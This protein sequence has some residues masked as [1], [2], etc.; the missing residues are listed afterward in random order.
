MIS[1]E[2][3]VDIVCPD[4][5]IKKVFDENIDNYTYESPSINSNGRISWYQIIVNAIRNSSGEIDYALELI[6]PITEL[7]RT[8]EALKK[9]EEEYRT[10]FESMIDP[11]II[12]DPDGNILQINKS[13]V[14]MLGYNSVEEL[15]GR[16]IL[17]FC[18]D[19]EQVDRLTKEI[20]NIGHLKSS[21]F[22]LVKKDGSIVNTIISVNVRYDENGKI[23]RYEG[24]YKDITERR[25]T[26][27]K[28]ANIQKFESIGIFASGIAHDLNNIL[29]PILGNISLAK[30]QKDPEIINEM[31][32]DAEKAALMARDL[33][34]Q[35]LTFSK[36]GAPV[37][38]P[39]SISHILKDSVNFA[40]RGT[41]V[42]PEISIPNDLWA[43]DIDE[44]QI[45][46]VI[47]NIILNADQAMPNGGFIEVKAENVYINMENKLPLKEGKY[48]RI[49]IKDYGVGIPEK[50]LSKIFD[51]YWTTKKNW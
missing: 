27:E 4:C 35:L 19:K 36:R 26:E 31:L 6:T 16:S 1:K 3:Y 34:Q 43:V 9:S 49:S 25:K 42:R 5:G 48:I 10:L 29:T 50:Y 33:T 44:G 12:L 32:S 37:K 40:L 13:G 20:K 47:T 38:R 28:L 11:I 46:Q 51:P 30:T 24:F 7:K 22:D 23:I 8:Q 15:L 2:R 17:D 14:E 21:E 18:F 39:T 41:N 45:S